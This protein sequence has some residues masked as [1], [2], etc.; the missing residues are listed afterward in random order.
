MTLTPEKAPTVT[1]LGA[2]LAGSE[3]A[4]TL[5]QCGLQVTLL[6]MKPQQRTPAARSNF[7][8]ELVCSNSLRSSN[9]QNAVGLLKEEMRRLGSLVLHTAL[10]HRVPAGD[11]LAVDREQFGQAMEAALNQH[12][13]I[14]RRCATVER[15]PE[16]DAGPVVVATGPLTADALAQDLAARCGKEKLYFY[17]AL[18]PIV[19]G[20]SIDRSVVFAASRYD[21]GEGADYLNCPFTEEQYTL[22]LDALL[23][24]QSMPCH[25]FED[26]KFFQGCMPVEEVAKSGRDALRFGAMK[27][28]G[29]TC[30]KTQRRPYSVLQLRKEDA[31]GQAYNLVG[32]QTKLKYPEQLRVFRLI[33]GLQEANFVRLGAIHRNTYLDSPAL[34]DAG[35]RLRSQ[36][37]L[38]IAGQLTG[39]EG[40]VE[41]AA[42]GLCVALQVAAD[43]GV[44]P[45]EVPPATCALGALWRHVLGETRLK[46]RP[47]EPSN[48]NWSLFPPADAG[49][50]KNETK[51]HRL[52]RAQTAFEAW[53]ARLGKNLLPRSTVALQLPHDVPTSRAG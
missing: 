40:Y 37:N 27:P 23:A 49:V 31:G 28:V 9:L 25:S 13:R 4:Y 35:M 21:K 43:L 18:A 53:A 47:H 38:Y 33:P 16:R 26:A 48:I 45:F 6:E 44:Q 46:G 14:E 2:G 7:C 20:D 30:P 22:F 12:P 3:A 1:V 8:A 32:F 52:G 19:S 5:A 41:S 50:R 11:A 42:H 17:D 39:V 24:A 34:L 15:L 10:Q 36:P 51:A 29:L